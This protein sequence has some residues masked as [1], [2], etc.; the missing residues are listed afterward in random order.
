MVEI[1]PFKGIIYDKEKVRDV[2]KVISP[3]YDV[4]SEEE[5]EKYYS[6]DEHNIVRI[7]LGKKTEH[8][9]ES[10]NRYSRAAH[11][12]Q[13]WMNEGIFA[14]DDVPGL[15]VYEQ[16]F[17]HKKTNYSRR[18]FIGLLRLDQKGS[19]KVHENTYSKPKEDRL[20]LM[21]ACS[22]NT[23]P[24]FVLYKGDEVSI[25]E[26]EPLFSAKDDNEVTHR[27]WRVTDEKA[28]SSFCKGFTDIS[29]YIADGHHRYETALNYAKELKVNPDSAN[30]HNYIMTYFVEEQDPGLLVL[31]IH[32]ILNIS[33]EDNDLIMK[34]AKRHFLVVEV[35]SFAKI[36]KAVGHVFGYFSRKDNKMYMFKLRDVVTK[37]RVMAEKGRQALAELDVAILHSLLIDD[38]LDK[39]RDRKTETVI[40]Y[41]HDDAEAV[42]AVKKGKAVC[43]F[44]LNPTKISQIMSI[45]DAGGR[46][47]QKSTFFYPKP[48]SG[49]VMRKIA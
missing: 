14:E 20:L 37:N 4:I 30:P 29:A 24:I 44:L 12:M 5:Q 40:T 23:E 13:E 32:R 46:M 18:G 42:A 1:K 16:Q 25:P 49:L 21:R 7:I 6:K 47:P 9:N 10:E 8:D 43:A 26:E 48:Y 28:V 41:S 31:P 22:A 11:F 35:D 33:D 27:F 19:V 2:S 34:N 38:I 39:Y 3:P 17:T 36:E 45:A 15:Y